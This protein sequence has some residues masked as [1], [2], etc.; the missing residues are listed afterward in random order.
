MMF[1]TLGLTVALMQPSLEAQNFPRGNA[2]EEARAVGALKTINTAEAVYQKAYSSG[3]SPTLAALG[4]G[5][6]WKNPSASAAGLIDET[7]TA[8]KLGG[9]A[10]AC[11]AGAPDAMGRIGTYTVTARPLRWHRGARSF[12]TDQ[13]GVIRWTLQNRPATTL[14]LEI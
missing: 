8:G 1:L 12:Y 11:K 6:G 5:K 13:F 4:M 3:Y 2:D 10:F 7:L 9:Y 14:D